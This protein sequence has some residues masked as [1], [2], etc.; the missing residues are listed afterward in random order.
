MVRGWNRTIQRVELLAQHQRHVECGGE[1]YVVESELVGV[2]GWWVEWRGEW[3]RWGERILTTPQPPLTE[4]STLRGEL[5]RL[6]ES[7]LGLVARRQAIAS[8]I[9]LIKARA[10]R[11]TRDFVQEKEVIGRVRRVATELELDPNFAERLAL[12]LIRASLTIQEQDRVLAS[13]E[14]EGRKVLIIGGAGKMGRWFARFLHSQGFT[15]EIADPAGSRDE[16]P[17]L[18]DWRTSTLE[19]DILVVATPLRQSAT[20]LEELA[21][22]KPRGIVFDVGSLKT[23]L[24]PGLTKLVE[25]G[26]LVTSVHPMFGPDTDLL[27]GRHI[28]FVDVG[29][30]EATRR[31]RDLFSSTMAVQVEM[32]L[33]AHDRTVAYIL[34]LSH[35]VN[36]AFLAAL[37]NSGEDAEKLKRLS[38]TTF[39]AQLEVARR[40]ASENPHLYFEIQSLNEYGVSAL[41]GLMAAVQQVRSAVERGDEAEFTALMRRG[42]DYLADV[43]PR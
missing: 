32:D 35:A 2:R 18:D 26:V 3:W 42:A 28:I 33:D 5:A 24:R 7:L 36:I 6:D 16:F 20:I 8:Q 27:S 9:G 41:T 39:D 4:L 1:Q 12:L 29:V 15:V 13:A 34:G 14:G 31:V 19:H 43:Q 23:P 22:R 10:G 21:A 37:A 38:S 30:P 17:H 25:A 40:V 11:S